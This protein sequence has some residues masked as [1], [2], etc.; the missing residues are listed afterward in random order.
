MPYDLRYC[1]ICKKRG[2]YLN[3]NG[4]RLNEINA[5]IKDDFCA[6]FAF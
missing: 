4:K 3:E 1:V 5:I 6:F 2:D